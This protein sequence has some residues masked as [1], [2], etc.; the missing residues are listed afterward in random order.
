MT[1]KT[2]NIE[3]SLMKKGFVEYNTHHRYFVFMYDGKIQVKTKISH[4]HSEIGDDLIA[5]MSKQLNMS[6]NFFK[7]FIDCT[8]SEKEYIKELRD[9]NIID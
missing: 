3:K 7:D 9:K 8:K 2:R 4:S 6:K 1:L 5:Q